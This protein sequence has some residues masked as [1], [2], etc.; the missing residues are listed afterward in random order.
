MTKIK[1]RPDLDDNKTIGAL[2]KETEN[3]IRMLKYLEGGDE[4][5]MHKL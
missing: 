5:G 4:Y 1:T 3:D 2:V